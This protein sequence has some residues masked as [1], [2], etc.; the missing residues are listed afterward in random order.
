M[1]W[2]LFKTGNSFGFSNETMF[3]AMDQCNL[4]P[5][6]AKFFFQNQVR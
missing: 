1:S 6:L 4:R 5:D 2:T 3:S